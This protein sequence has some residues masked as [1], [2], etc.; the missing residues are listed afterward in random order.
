MR[1]NLC[2]VKVND[3]LQTVV[4]ASAQWSARGRRRCR[5][6]GLAKRCSEHSSLPQGSQGLGVRAAEEV[7]PA[8]EAQP[9]QTDCPRHLYQSAMSQSRSAHTCVYRPNWAAHVYAPQGS[10]KFGHTLIYD[11]LC[12]VTT[13]MSCKVIDLLIEQIIRHVAWHGFQGPPGNET[14]LSQNSPGPYADNV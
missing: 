11:N 13:E 2:E 9:S 12:M 1:F 8:Q 6:R 7:V 14:A 3:C 5:G 4:S 10:G